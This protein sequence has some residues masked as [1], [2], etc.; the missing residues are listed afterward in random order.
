MPLLVTSIVNPTY[1]DAFVGLIVLLVIGL[2]IYF[3]ISR[4]EAK[5]TQYSYLET[6]RI[7]LDRTQYPYSERITDAIISFIVLLVGFS[8]FAVLS[9]LFTGS[10]LGIVFGI[11]G[12]CFLGAMF[13]Q[14]IANLFGYQPFW[15][16]IE[17]SSNPVS[18]EDEISNLTVQEDL[19]TKPS[20]QEKKQLQSNPKSPSFKKGYLVIIAILSILCIGLLISFAVLPSTQGPASPTISNLQFPTATYD[21]PKLQSAYEVVAPT[22]ETKVASVNVMPTP[23]ISPAG[24]PIIGNWLYGSLQDGVSPHDYYKIHSDGTY[25][26]DLRASATDTYITSGT[27]ISRGNNS[28]SM[29]DHQGISKPINYDP[30]Y[31]TLYYTYLPYILSPT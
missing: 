5:K 21:N 7:R 14:S 26:E 25:F 12:L 19:G 20:T 2:I 15:K 27:W 4:K 6:V 11:I 23:V 22:P 3:F 13:I 10:F 30:A 16:M 18:Q 29:I 24:D 28:Y 9:N 1:R 31:N 8:I 17:R